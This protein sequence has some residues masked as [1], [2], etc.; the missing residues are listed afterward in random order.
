MA[1]SPE[2]AFVG[3]PRDDTTQVDG[4]AVYH[5]DL[6]PVRGGHKCYKAKGAKLDGVERDVVD[7]VAAATLVLGKTTGVCNDAARD[8][9]AHADADAHATC[10]RAKAAKGSPKFGGA[11][12]EYIDQIGR[13]ET[14]LKKLAE[15]CFPASVEGS[16]VSAIVDRYTCYKTKRVK[17]A[18]K[19]LRQSMSIAD[20]LEDKDTE[21]VKPDLFCLASTVDAVPPGSADDHLACYK[22]RDAK[23][24]P[25]FV[26]TSVAASDELVAQTAALIKPSRVCLPATL[27]P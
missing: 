18:P 21:F 27:V 13:R 14:T 10:Y 3:V 20:S 12:I 1:V 24:E 25:K 23:G 19:F 15:M 7:A 8:G 2:G 16:P 9:L 17:G 5:F 4:G 6:P 26:G 11:T 22:A